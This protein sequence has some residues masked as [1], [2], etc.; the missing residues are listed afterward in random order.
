MITDHN[1]ARELA[2]LV[3]LAEGPAHEA[4]DPQGAVE[5]R[6][7]ERADRLDF[8]E[9]IR[10]RLNDEQE[11]CLVYGAFILALKP[12]EICEQFSG[13]FESVEEVYR[14]KQNVL[15]RLRRDAELAKNLAG[16][17]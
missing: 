7:L 3:E 13:I 15:A 2:E 12:R 8:W 6:A 5:E 14:V 4:E 9:T 1:R 10:A 11:R 16:R 17:D